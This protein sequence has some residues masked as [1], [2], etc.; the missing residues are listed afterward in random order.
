MAQINLSSSSLS[1]RTYLHVIRRRR[2]LIVLVTLL[3][4]FFATL[5]ALLADPVYAS[6]AKIQVASLQEGSLFD[7]DAEHPNRVA[8]SLLNEIEILTSRPTAAEVRNQVPGVAFDGP[9]VTP[10]GFSET[11]E[12]QIKADD[13]TVAADVANAF[14]DVFVAD[15]RTR[16]VGALR[17]QEKALRE[18]S[19]IASA[20][21]EEVATQLQDP[22]LAPSQLTS[23]QVRQANLAGLIQD[24]ESRADQLA[25]D[26]DLRGEATQVVAYGA[27]QPSPLS[28]NPMQSAMIGTVLGVLLGLALAVVIDMAQDKIASEEDLEAVDSDL[29]VLTTVPH[30]KIETGP[31][32]D[33]AVLEAFRYLKTGIRMYGLSAEVRSVIVTSAIGSEGKTT[34]AAFLAREMSDASDK[35]VLIDCDLRRPTVHEHFGVD[36]EV[37]LTS[38]VLG[39]AQISDAIH[40]VADNLAIVPAGPA[41][42]NPT[43][44]IGSK[45]FA[46]IV[47]SI[48]DQADFTI[49]DSPPVLPVADTLI[50]GQ[51][52]DAAILVT[53]IGEVRRRSIR[54]LLRRL[55]DAEIPVVG[56]VANDRPRQSYYGDYDGY[57]YYEPTRPALPAATKS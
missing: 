3:V 17:T 48:V 29:P 12:I 37:G 26:A 52:V 41:V 28:P 11:V 32:E 40:F 36:N 51:L 25:V 2:R 13:P 9:H 45:R 7:D 19:A 47:Q 46:E 1:L 10:V 16:S 34:T 54:Q 43:E 5:P 15:R 33:Q 31:V 18:Q 6:T 8:V 23:L 44:M 39:D 42:H 49:L 22:E 14:A 53:R 21:L 35:V 38:L 55:E 20:Q 24:Y 4:A 57:S 56:F 50:A 30:A 27:V